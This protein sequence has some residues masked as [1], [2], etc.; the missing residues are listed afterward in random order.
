M[1]GTEC[2]VLTSLLAQ[3]VLP[4]GLQFKGQAA[5]PAVKAAA[6][7]PKPAPAKPAPAKPAVSGCYQRSI[8]MAA[9]PL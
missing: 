6:P 9:R 4:E 2:A 7:A 5:A 8:C 3:G 1:S